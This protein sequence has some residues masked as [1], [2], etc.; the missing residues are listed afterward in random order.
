LSLCFAGTDV[1]LEDDSDV[2]QL[3]EGEIVEVTM[4]KEE[5]EEEQDVIL[6]EDEDEVPAL[7]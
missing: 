5:E 4:S 6:V 7:E 3:E 2:L 1:V